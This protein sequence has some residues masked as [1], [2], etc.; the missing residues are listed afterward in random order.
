MENKTMKTAL[1]DNVR[2]FIINIPC[3]GHLAD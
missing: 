3:I 1:A 2:L